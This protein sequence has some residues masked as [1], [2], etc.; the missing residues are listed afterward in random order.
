MVRSPYD[1][2]KSA[3][4]EH[5]FWGFTALNTRNQAFPGPRNFL[6][7]ELP[8]PSPLFAQVGERM[9]DRSPLALTRRRSNFIDAP[10]SK[11]SWK[12]CYTGM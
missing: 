1:F 2:I 9:A 7:P 10:L 5:P 6:V 8:L 4:T 11:T 3:R 12:L